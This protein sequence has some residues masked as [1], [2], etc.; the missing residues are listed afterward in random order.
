[1]HLATTNVIFQDEHKIKLEDLYQRMGVTYEKGLTTNEVEMKFKTFGPNV[2]TE[3]K[4]TPWY[5]EYA[6]ENMTFFSLML[7]AGAGFSFFAY[8]LD[9]SDPSTVIML[10]HFSLSHN[11]I[12]IAL[13]GLCLGHRTTHYC[14]QY[15]HAKQKE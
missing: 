11:N 10:I 14:D 6:H 13:F 4:R 9:E 12:H 2:L 5:V 1:M 3:K 8:G 7:W 15:L